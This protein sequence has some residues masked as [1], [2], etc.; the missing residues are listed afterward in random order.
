MIIFIGGV[1]ATNTVI[2]LNEPINEIQETQYSYLIEQINQFDIVKYISR[3]Y[4]SV[5]VEIQDYNNESFKVFVDFEENKIKKISENETQTVDLE[6]YFSRED[7]IYLFENWEKIST[8]EKIK[9][10]LRSEMPIKDIL[11]FS[12]IA[13]SVR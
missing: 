8:F 7:I 3:H 1:N 12:A 2:D 13:M 10:F 5:S 6:L 11:T 9:F 4:N